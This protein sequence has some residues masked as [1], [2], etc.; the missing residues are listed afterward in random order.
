MTV[1]HILQTQ[2]KDS[3]CSIHSNMLRESSKFGVKGVD[4]LP[5]FTITREGPSVPNNRVRDYFVKDGS[6]KTVTGERSFIFVYK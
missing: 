4:I 5:F 3:D 2:D 1:F 6:S